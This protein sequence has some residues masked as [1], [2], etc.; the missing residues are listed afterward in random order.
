MG[1]LVTCLLPAMQFKCIIP[2]QAFIF[3]FLPSVECSIIKGYNFGDNKMNVRMG[4]DGGYLTAKMPGHVP[5]SITVCARFKP[6]FK[7]HGDRLGLLNIYIPHDKKWP[8]F[9]IVCRSSGRCTMEFHGTLITKEKNV[10]PKVNWLQKWSSICVG[11]DYVNDTITAFFNGAE[12]NRTK[13]E[14]KRE[15]PLDKMFPEGYFSSSNL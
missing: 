3:L 7:R 6:D 1:Y 2:I 15:A 4:P 13:E 12:V 11:L 14:E 9:N 10:Y 5:A 8:V